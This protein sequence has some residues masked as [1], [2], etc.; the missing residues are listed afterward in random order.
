MKR[1]FAILLKVL[2]SAAL[3]APALAA[4]DFRSAQSID[5]FYA[6]MA[7]FK[8]ANGLTGYI[9]LQG[10]TV[11]EPVWDGGDYFCEGRARVKLGDCYG[12]IDESGNVITPA[13][14]ERAGTY[15]GGYA[16]VSNGTH[17]ALIDLDGNLVLEPEW[18]MLGS[19]SEGLISFC[20]TDASGDN[21][22]GYINLD[23]EVVLAPQ[24][25]R[26]N[27]FRNGIAVVKK[28][29]MYGCIDAAGNEVIPFIYD[30]ISPFNEGLACVE[31]NDLSGYIDEAGNP[32]IPCK[33]DSASTFQKDR[34]WVKQDGAYHLIDSRDNTV[35]TSTWSNVYI[36]FGGSDFSR[37]FQGD[38]I[39]YVNLDG[40]IALRPVYDK[41][42]RFCDGVAC[43]LWNGTWYLIDERGVDLRNGTNTQA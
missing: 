33:Y 3:C 19:Y 22:Y 15:S 6:G 25:E 8:A 41:A 20:S 24:W 42:T 31:Q 38:K 26:A 9:N 18:N 11:I 14:W 40:E 39:G 32:V 13:N 43:V 37:V 30:D 5:N 12:Y 28:D 29:G 27:A 10:E 36:D 34:A 4:E 7:A 2:L 23:G 17:S 1:K 16:S 21:A 35:G